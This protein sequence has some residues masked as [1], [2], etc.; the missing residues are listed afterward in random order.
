MMGTLLGPEGTTVK[1]ASAGA[2][3]WQLPAGWLLFRCQAQL[4][5]HTVSAWLVFGLAGLGAGVGGSGCG[6]VVG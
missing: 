3:A 6:L 1:S 5:S 4:G 2:L